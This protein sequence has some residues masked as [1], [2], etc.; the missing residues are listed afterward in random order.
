M[1]F[2]K[3]FISSLLISSLCL[4]SFAFAAQTTESTLAEEEKT[5]AKP[6]IYYK[7]GFDNVNVD[8]MPGTDILSS[9]NQT[10]NRMSVQPVPSNENKSLTI[11][12]KSDQSAI[13]NHN[14]KDPAY[15]KV[16]VQ[17]TLR[18]DGKNRDSRERFTLYDSG[19]NS[20]HIFDCYAD[21]NIRGADGKA[22]GVQLVQNKFMTLTAAVDLDKQTYDVYVNYKLR[23]QNVP[24]KTNM[25]DI[26][27]FRYTV[28]PEAVSKAKIYI[29]EI[30][31]YEGDRALSPEM[32]AKVQ[33]H[34]GKVGVGSSL[35][36]N[37]AFCVNAPKAVAWGDTL[38][39]DETNPLA[40][41]YWVDEEIY[42]PLRFTIEQLGGKVVWNSQT[43][44]TVCEI[45][46]NTIEFKEGSNLYKLNGEE[47]S[48]KAAAQNYYGR[49][50]VS[51]N[52]ICEVTGNNL[53]DDRS[54]ILI[55]GKGELNY[56]WDTDIQFFWDL[57]KEICHDVPSGYQIIQDLRA[58]NPNF[59]HPRLMATN[60]DF[61]II[62]NEIST[63]AIKK[64]WFNRLKKTADKYLTQEPP[65]YKTD[66]IYSHNRTAGR[67]AREVTT[68][69]S[70]MYKLTDDVT[71]AE[72]AWQEVEALCKWP[73]WAPDLDTVINT[74]D[75]MIAV[76]TG[77][78]WLY[79][80]LNLQQRKLVRDAALEY[81][82]AYIKEQFDRKIPWTLRGGY[83]FD[84]GIGGGVIMLA[85][86]MGDEED[87]RSA[88]M[89][90]LVM[91]NFRSSIVKYLPD[92]AWYEGAGYWAS[93]LYWVQVV[94]SLE[95]AIGSDYGLLNLPVYPEAALFP[96]ALSP[97]TA[98]FN[99]S[100]SIAKEMYRFDTG[101]LGYFATRLNRPDIM[102]IRYQHMKESNLQPTWYDLLFFRGDPVLP[103]LET[104][105]DLDYYFRD[106]E[107]I[108]MRNN[109]SV[110]NSFY[111]GMH[112]GNNS[113]T[114]AHLDIGQF[115]LEAFGD[116]FAVD[117]GTDDYAIYPGNGNKLY[118]LRAEGH[119]VIVINPDGAT[120]DMNKKAKSIFE[121]YESNEV[122]AFGITDTTECYPD[123]V[124]SMRRGIKMTNGRT[125]VIIQDEIRSEKENE[126]Y[127]FMHTPADIEI[128]EDGKTAMLDINGNKME[129]KILTEQGKFT[130][131]PARP[132]S[133][134][135]DPEGQNKNEE[136]QKL[137]VYFEKVKDVDL[138]ICFTPIALI[139]ING[140]EY[141]EFTPFDKWE[142]DDPAKVK[143]KE[144]PKLTD[145]KIDGQT[146][147][148]FDGE[149]MKYNLTL[150]KNQPMPNVTA[151][152]DD[153][154]EIVY[155]DALPGTITVNVSNNDYMSKYLIVVEHFPENLGDKGMTELKIV[156]AT[157]PMVDETSEFAAMNSIDEI[158]NTLSSI[159]T[160]AEITYE[161]EK[162]S[163]ID[164]IEMMLYRGDTR[165]IAFKVETS[166]DG[167]NWTH[168]GEYQSSGTT[169][170]FET[171]EIGGVRAKYIRVTATGAMKNGTGSW[172][173]GTFSPV[174]FK[175]YC[176]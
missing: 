25:A 67:T 75:I 32:F 53:L 158:L 146:I 38:K 119:N 11:E 2:L 41:P 163:T 172:A 28:G 91:E 89:L 18:V 110:N 9:Y 109:W 46:G 133:F 108:S 68:L 3:A 72:R 82:F 95:S 78:D 4:P 21:D 50:F 111:A 123:D 69:L 173:A 93:I 137:T 126:V 57:A 79:D 121:Q 36:E 17:I 134:S 125:S 86:A 48:M 24:F 84:H 52:T 144:F 135:P 19:G 51:A 139:P 105:M 156:K 87:V 102:S 166:L 59:A 112:S 100:D 147:A 165:K 157:S 14:L 39:I 7:Q 1:K 154:V 122:S 120:E 117:L 149:N 150:R 145:L 97:G 81:G 13:A 49:L 129:A 132:F 155:P 63:S 16:C 74:G 83:N 85:L 114:H 42:I 34:G 66:G 77:Y 43:N 5:T 58:A 138:S 10:Q 73:A 96:Y 136:Y 153:K 167:V 88:E 40:K 141:P 8:A 159:A 142:L 116:R 143:I 15:G 31:V 6:S 98:L 107:A 115:I 118:R 37:L 44:E 47:K 174:E 92:G 99:F 131:L 168:A 23:V 61:E 152:S 162:E 176:K 101:A 65:T 164:Y 12:M 29:D 56:S 127:W 35:L 45:D 148:G 30:S 124:T 26:A 169:D 161:L 104:A 103:D 170:K 106:T 22:L 54:G 130:V 171:Y 20:N 113:A 76:A 55:M 62:K 140:M 71:Y 60:E 33:W 128:S 160:P 94:A 90:D 151:T 80:Y 64:D 70:L 27:Q 175:A